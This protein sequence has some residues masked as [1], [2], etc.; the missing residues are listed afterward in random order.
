MVIPSHG[1]E[2]TPE[3]ELIDLL[4]C[5]RSETW[6]CNNQLASHSVLN[7]LTPQDSVDIW[8]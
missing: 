8:F 1:R 4:S 3:E 6:H 2:E 7:L 5:H